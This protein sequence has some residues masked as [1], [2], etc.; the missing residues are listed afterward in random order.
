[1]RHPFAIDRDVR[2][3]GIRL[4]TFRYAP[5][6]VQP[7]HEHATPSVSLI[8]RGR[9]VERVGLR[10]VEA[11]PLSVAVKP[12]GVRHANR[13]GPEG[14][15]ALQVTFEPCAID[16]GNDPWRPE[17]W[18]W[19][20]GGPPARPF[21]ALLASLGRTGAAAP[22]GN[23]L[24]AM[25][26]D[27]CATLAPGDASPPPL[28]SREG[29]RPPRW[30]ARA[31]DRLAEE[32]GETLRV[33]DLA[34]EAGVHPVSLARAYRRHYGMSI[35][36]AMRRRRVQLAAVRL[37]AGE[38]PLCEVALGAGFADQS[39]LCRCFKGSTGL[40]PLRYRRLARA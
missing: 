27:V 39:H 3:G 2:H 6:A 34:R 13:F 16:G 11:A 29:A 10:E 5:G 26:V 22:G 1:M 17:D 24:E 14:A 33:R 38:E 23:E 20:H 18:R 12:A 32:S 31:H 35:T 9:L 7:P 37:G 30:L 8:F 40:T 4:R 28:G 21:L 19:I 36:A 15:S 25:V